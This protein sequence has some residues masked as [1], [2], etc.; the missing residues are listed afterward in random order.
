[1]PKA[2]TTISQYSYSLY[3]IISL[4]KHSFYTVHITKKDYL[5]I[6]FRSRYEYISKIRHLLRWQQNEQLLSEICVTLK[7]TSTIIIKLS[8]WSYMVGDSSIKLSPPLLHYLLRKLLLWISVFIHKIRAWN[9]KM[10]SE[11]ISTHQKQLL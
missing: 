7:S 4:K 2:N 8:T 11:I 1:M 6:S 3:F 5:S 9:T 10:V